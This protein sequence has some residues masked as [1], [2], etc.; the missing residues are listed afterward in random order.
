MAW[1]GGEALEL[2]LTGATASQV[3]SWGSVRP[4]EM[5]LFAKPHWLVEGSFS[6]QRTEVYIA[7]RH[8]STFRMKHLRCS[9]QNISSFVSTPY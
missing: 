8:P 9:F 6:K 4:L 5:N 2:G 7:L 3:Y 1:Q